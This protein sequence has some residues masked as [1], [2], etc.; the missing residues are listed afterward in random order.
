[1]SQGRI[2]FHPERVR[3]PGPELFE[4]EAWRAQA[5]VSP[6]TAGRG[7]TWFI[8]DG[9]RHL[10][11][12]GYRRG[13]VVGRFIH[14]W[15]LYTGEA[16]TRPAREWRVLRYV[17]DRGLPGPVALAARYVRE[18]PVYRADILTRR[19]PDT[20]PLS[21]ALAADALP[22]DRWEDIGRCIRRFHDAGVWHA[23]LNAHNILLGEEGGVYLIDFDRATLRGPGAWTRGNLSR[24]ERSLEKLRGLGGGLHLEPG[25]WRALTRAYSSDGA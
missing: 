9:E 15:Y 1:M 19:L 2:W 8:R 4:P 18:G 5:E 24:L 17:E 13:G 3:S 20:T 16:R 14:D 21:E 25:D 11:L 22:R 23:D 10:V 6:A 12:R 7:A